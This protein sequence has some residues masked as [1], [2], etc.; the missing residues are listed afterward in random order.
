MTVKLFLGG[1]CGNN[2][3]RDDFI[4]HLVDNGIDRQVIFNPVVADWNEEAQIA[5]EKAK[6]EAEYMLYYI[7]DPKQEGLNVSGYSLI[8][9]T[10]GLYDKPSTT[11]VVFDEEGFTNPHVKKSMAQAE[12]VLR[13]RFP[14]AKIFGD[15]NDAINWFIWRNL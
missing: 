1:T 14:S 15:V 13:K 8:E 4:Q 6:A 5:E 10:M 7:G 11:I 9:A 12:K 3:W 2:N